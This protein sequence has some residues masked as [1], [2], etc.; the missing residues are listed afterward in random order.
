MKMTIRLLFT[1]FI[2]AAV[3]TNWAFAASEKSAGSKPK[4]A[5]ASK[6]AVSPEKKK[7]QSQLP[8]M[9][10]EEQEDKNAPLNITSQRMVSEKK[11]SKISFYGSVV[12]IKG[13]LKVEADEMHVFSDKTQEN[14]REMEAIG[15][16]RI[17]HKDKIAT[18]KK[19]VYYG[20]TQTLVLTGDP[21]LTQGKNVATGEKVVYRFGL[22][23]MEITSGQS[24]PAAIT[25]FPKQEKDKTPEPSAAAPPSVKK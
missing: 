4:K 12:A 14:L 1:V 21:V 18:G 19:A 25:L 24:Q 2:V 3:A 5:T 8:A 20:D 9:L 15:S 23:D 10:D 11:S 6:P 7:E 16:V 17:T 13:K 22:E